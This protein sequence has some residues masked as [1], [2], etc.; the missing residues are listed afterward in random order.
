MAAM[1][2]GFGKSGL[3]CGSPLLASVLDACDACARVHHIAQSPHPQARYTSA[4]GA[5]QMEARG[6][7][8]G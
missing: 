3:G 4:C 8:Q 1:E 2:C 6:S 5:S 7:A